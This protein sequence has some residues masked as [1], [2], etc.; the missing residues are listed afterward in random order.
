MFAATV[1]SGSVKR[2]DPIPFQDCVATFGKWFHRKANDGGRLCGGFATEDR[3]LN[4]ALGTFETCRQMATTSVHRGRA[5]VV[6]RRPNR[7]EWANYF[8]VGTVSKAYRALDSY[9]AMRLRR[10]LQFKHKVRRRKGGN[11]PLP[12]PR[13]LQTRTPNCA[14]ARRAV[15]EGV[16][17]CP[18]A[19]CGKSACPGSM[20]VAP[21]KRVEVC[22][23]Q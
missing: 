9:A 8:K 4:S 3:A 7:R 22:R 18:R 23:L 14:W 11:Y 17:S 1:A 19:G 16:K 5:E 21:C 15:G 6:G 12:H 20:S 10:W 2:L 13:A